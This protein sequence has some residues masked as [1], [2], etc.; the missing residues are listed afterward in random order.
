MIDTFEKKKRQFSLVYV[1]DRCN[2]NVPWL[3]SHEQQAD[4]QL[5]Y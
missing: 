1:L 3:F 2:A 4:D 5:G